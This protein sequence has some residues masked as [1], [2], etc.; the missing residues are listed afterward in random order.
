MVEKKDIVCV[1]FQR[2]REQIEKVVRK[3]NMTNVFQVGDA[4]QAG[5]N[6][7]RC[8]SRI[9]HIIDDIYTV[10]EGL[11]ANTDNEQP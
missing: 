3:K 10:N 8:Q 2:S 7:G 1:C 4:I 6:C 11:F 5:T 9:Q